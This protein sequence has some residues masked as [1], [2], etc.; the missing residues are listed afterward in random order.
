[1]T[2]QLPPPPVPADVDLTDFQYMPLEVS[3]L[4][5]SKAWLVCKRRPELAFYMLNLW[6]AAWHERP[7]GSLEDD[8]DVLANF[9]M[10][11]PEKWP[12]VKTEVLRGWVK[13]NDQRL[14]HPVVIEKVRES[15][16]SKIDHQ[17]DRECGRLRKAWVR[18]KQPGAF[19]PP[20]FE[21]WE[22]QRM[23]A[24][25]NRMSN[26]HGDISNGH[27]PE[28][29]GT[30]HRCPP[31]NPLNV[32]EYKGREGKGKGHVSETHA[33]GGHPPDNLP[34]LSD[35]E[36]HERFESLR[37]D[38]PECAGNEDWMTAEHHARLLVERN[39]A[40]WDFLHDRVRWFRDWVKAGGV[41]GPQY[42]M[43]PVTYFTRKDKPWSKPWDPPATKAEQRL[44]SNIAAAAEAKRRLFGDAK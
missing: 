4:R 32:R 37:A 23:S 2:D 19:V 13:C 31:E 15:W 10:C 16:R 36:S 5:R 24:G 7:A 26:G 11:S 43:G 40:T 35:A 39:E 17:Y 22:R 27:T 30:S 8:D 44:D 18:T 21:E 3:R 29:L 20:T 42:V 41:S 1:V 14:Y 28:F 34:M 38:Y 25:N 9:A 6:T 12:K 33:S